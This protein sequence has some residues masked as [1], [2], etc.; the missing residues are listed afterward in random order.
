[1]LDSK[2]GPIKTTSLLLSALGA[3]ALVM[4]SAG[5][6]AILAYSVSQRT[7]EIGI[8]VALGAQRREVL[9]VVMQRTVMLIACGIGLGL[10]A[11]ALSRVFLNAVSGIGGLDAV[12]CI[13]VALLLGAV[14]IFA[15]Y[16]PARK[17]LRV[18]PMQ[19][20]RCE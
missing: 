12:T 19:A 13:S 14:A 4:A 5:I 2:V 6:Y 7:R 18:D 16:L 3:L 20:L 8:R 1:M 15:S 17:A 11:L 9:A 10:T